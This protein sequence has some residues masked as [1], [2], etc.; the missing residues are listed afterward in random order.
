MTGQYVHLRTDLPCPASDDHS[1]IGLKY[2]MPACLGPLLLGTGSRVW[3]VLGGE[4]LMPQP[5]LRHIAR[6][7]VQV[8]IT[9]AG[10]LV[11]LLAFS[12]QARA[13]T[14]PAIGSGTVTSVTSA[15]TSAVASATS[16]ATSATSTATSATSAATT[17]SGT[18][19]SATTTPATSAATT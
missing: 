8:A 9:A 10:I 3:P 7:A 18:T 11:V 1:G 14:V 15:A 12:R 5:I 2:R 17:G 16:T 19:T 13:A 6:R 4:L